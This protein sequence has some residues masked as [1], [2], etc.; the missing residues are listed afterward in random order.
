MTQDKHIE[1]NNLDDWGKIINGAYYAKAAI[2]TTV[3]P[4][5]SKKINQ[6]MTAF[7]GNDNQILMMLA[8]SCRAYAQQIG[9][10]IMDLFTDLMMEITQYE[11]NK[12]HEETKGIRMDS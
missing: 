7:R 11:D 3:T 4:V 2:V 6:V 1:S 5:S 10:E 8:A 9:V 12:V